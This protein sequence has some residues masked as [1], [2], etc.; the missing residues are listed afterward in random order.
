MLEFVPDIDDD[1]PLPERAAE[2]LPPMSPAEELEMRARTIKLLSDMT[3]TALTPDENDQKQARE[4]AHQMMAD[5]SVRPD[6]NKY[7]NEVMAYLAGMVSQTNCMIVDE[8]SELKLYVV[9]KLVYEI[10]HAKDSKSRIAA[11]SKLGEIDGVD[12]FKKRSE[13]THI[14]KP[15]AEVEKE[16]SSVLDSIEYTIIGNGTRALGQDSP[17]DDD[18][19]DSGSGES[20][21][22]GE[23]GED[24]DQVG[25]EAPN[26]DSVEQDER[27]E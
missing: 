4:L 5:P 7:P 14:L 25:Y 11:L 23:E 24:V 15:M 13:T 9:N 21:S 3:G 12:A 22:D 6:Y 8:L 2:A 20:G 17:E 27:R 10:E 26:Y 16:L 19:V 18:Q 1:V